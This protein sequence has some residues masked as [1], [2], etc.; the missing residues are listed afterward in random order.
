MD[1]IEVLRKAEGK[2]EK[3]I[4]GDQSQNKDLYGKETSKGGIK[5]EVRRI[6]IKE[7]ENQKKTFEKDC[8]QI[9][10]V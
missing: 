9:L 10:L 8:E 6:R 7:K 2:G 4:N 5:S 1:G 3:W